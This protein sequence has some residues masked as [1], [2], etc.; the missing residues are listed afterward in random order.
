LVRAMFRI[1]Q[2]VT[3]RVV[4][5]VCEATR[6]LP[7]PRAR[8]SSTIAASSRRGSLNTLSA[9]L[10]NRISNSQIPNLH[11]AICNWNDQRTISW[12]LLRLL[13]PKCWG[14]CSLPHSSP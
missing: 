4:P 8:R 12:C 10:R 7:I 1:A 14:K 9:C 5:A 6:Q 2:A 3:R 13:L 11:F